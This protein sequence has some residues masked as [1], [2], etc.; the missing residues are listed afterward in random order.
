MTAKKPPPSKSSPARR[1]S[2]AGAGAAQLPVEMLSKA[3]AKTELKR[4]ADEIARH[5]ALYYQYDALS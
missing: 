2:P 4:L 1:A 5:D 3:A